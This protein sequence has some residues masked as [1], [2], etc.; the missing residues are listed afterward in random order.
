[1]FKSCN[2]RDYWQYISLDVLNH[3]EQNNNHCIIEKKCIER[4]FKYK[5]K[6]INILIKVT[7]GEVC[8]EAVE[9]MSMGNKL[10]VRMNLREKRL[11][12][13][14]ERGGEILQQKR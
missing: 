7:E 8:Y 3:V 4:N 11:Q 13:D 12:K 1:M 6:V 9:M 2:T 10:V 14:G 5:D